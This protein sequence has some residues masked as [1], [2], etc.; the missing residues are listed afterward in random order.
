MSKPDTYIL[1]VC[2]KCGKAC[3][4]HPKTV[5]NNFTRLYETRST[6]HDAPAST[7]EKHFG[8]PWISEVS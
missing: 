1:H 4:I 3:T 2:S 7:E 6:C 8:D 5:F